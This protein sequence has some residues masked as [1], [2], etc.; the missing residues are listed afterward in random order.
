MENGSNLVTAI[1]FSLTFSLLARSAL[2]ASFYS[3]ALGN[4][5]D[6]R[7]DVAGKE[8]YFTNTWAVEFD[9]RFERDVVS[10]IAKKH[11]FTL[12]GRV[13]LN[14]FQCVYVLSCISSYFS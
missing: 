9:P 13:S 11:G 8:G 12:L 2:G 14:K 6:W 7:R 1:I 5:T 4:I 10:K 3:N